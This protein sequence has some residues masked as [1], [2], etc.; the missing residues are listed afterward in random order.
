M[1]D[2]REE[3]KWAGKEVFQ[4]GLVL[5]RAGNIST[6]LTKER[7]L[8]SATGASLGNLTDEDLVVLDTKGARLLGTKEPSTEYLTH[9]EIYNYRADVNAVVHTHSTYATVLAYLKKELKRVNPEV[10]AILGTVPIVSEHPYGTKELAEAV[11]AA[12]GNNKVVLVQ[13]IG[14]I[15]VGQ[16]LTEAVEIAELVEEIAKMSYLVDLQAR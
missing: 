15:T 6:R 13:R 14:V 1:A 4:R 11:V 7:I 9:L 3:L 10:E 2:P 16:E 8:I 5:G 12:L